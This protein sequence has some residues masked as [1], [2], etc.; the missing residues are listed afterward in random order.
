M[1]RAGRSTDSPGRIHT[2]SPVGMAGRMPK[3]AARSRRSRG[4]TSAR[5]MCDVSPIAVVAS[6]D[7]G[8]HRGRLG[9]RGR[10]IGLGLTRAERILDDDEPGAVVEARLDAHLRQRIRHARKNVGRGQQ[11][12]APGHVPR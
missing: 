7:D 10:L 3:A 11:Q 4:F 1:G 8:Q 9:S 2:V 5:W 12:R 6:F